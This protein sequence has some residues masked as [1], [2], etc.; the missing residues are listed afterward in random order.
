MR[1]KYFSYVT[2][3]RINGDKKESE[4]FPSYKIIYVYT[5]RIVFYTSTQ[6]MNPT[7]EKEKTIPKVIDEDNIERVIYFTDIILDCGSSQNQLCYASNYP[8]IFKVK[9]YKLIQKYI[10]KSPDVKCL[11]V[12]FFESSYKLR[13]EKVAFICINDLR[14]LDSLIRFKNKLSRT[15]EKYQ[16][17]LGGDRY[18]SYNGLLRKQ[19]PFIYLKNMKQPVP[20]IARLFGKKIIL[21]NNDK[22]ASFVDNFSLYQLSQ[23]KV[24]Q[25]DKAIKKGIIKSNWNSEMEIK[26]S[27]DCCLVFPGGMIDLK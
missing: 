7:I 17:K 19:S 20:V 12:P 23:S 25:V 13:H 5:D 11:T 1:K 4:V 27:G 8:Q 14:E 26:P 3:Q 10:P 9:T 6:G 15:I 21:V 2:F 22:S 18:N 16:M 24:Y